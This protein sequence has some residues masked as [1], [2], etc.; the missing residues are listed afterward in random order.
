[1]TK[2]R[3]ARIDAGS[4]RRAPDTREPHE[5]KDTMSTTSAEI[6]TFIENSRKLTAPFAKAN[7]LSA[8]TFEKLARYHYEIAGDLLNLSLAQIAAAT[9][10]KDVPELVKK[11]AELAN[12][13]VAKQT[14]RSQDFLKIATEAQSD[15]TQLIDATANEFTK[16]LRAA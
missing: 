15:L 4:A 11:Q 7:E 6:N 13:Y 3:K 14:Q 10:S 2:A 9:Q 5:A 16:N 1:M 12:G 8:K